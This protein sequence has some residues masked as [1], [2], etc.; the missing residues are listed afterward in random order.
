ML[1]RLTCFLLRAP[2][3]W[4]GAVVAVKVIEVGPEDPTQESSIEREV[5]LLLELRHPNIVNLYRAAR[6]PVGQGTSVDA[7]VIKEV[8]VLVPYMVLFLPWFLFKDSLCLHLQSQVP[9]TDEA[10]TPASISSGSN[11]PTVAYE[12]NSETWM[13]MEFCDKGTLRDLLR[14]QF[15]F[16][17]NDTK[18]VNMQHAIYT[19]Q[20]I[21][22]GFQY[23]HEQ[24][25]L[26]GDL[27]PHNILLQTSGQDSRGFIAKVSSQC[28]I[29]YHVLI[30]Q[31]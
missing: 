26:H 17:D 3:A 28:S 27:K 8:S 14:N 22:R 4:N 13:V 11:P 12:G 10:S 16:K 9:Q 29:S 25:M 6:R 5:S 30:R 15:F 19:C 2:A 31:P 24:N 7:T 1:A 20:D 18:E 21:A 23:L